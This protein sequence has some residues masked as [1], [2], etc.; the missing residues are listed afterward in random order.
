[1]NAT[2][3]VCV[4]TLNHACLIDLPDHSASKQSPSPHLNF[5]DSPEHSNSIA[6]TVCFRKEK[7]AAG[8]ASA[9]GALR[10]AGGKTNSVYLPDSCA[11]SIREET[12]DEKLEKQFSKR[13][14]ASRPTVSKFVFTP[15]ISAVAHADDSPIWA[16]ALYVWKRKKIVNTE[17]GKVKWF[18]DAFVFLPFPAPIL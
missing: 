15:H 7:A 16:S 8:A 5:C 18:S 11:Q 12:L 3:P 4:R 2:L 10:C 17:F 9:I 13:P 6:R 14:R 1:M